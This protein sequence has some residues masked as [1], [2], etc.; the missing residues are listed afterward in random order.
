MDFST[1]GWTSNERR[2]S[3]YCMPGT[4]NRASAHG[5]RSTGA[6]LT[7]P[8]ENESPP[9]PRRP[10]ESSPP[11]PAGPLPRPTI[12]RPASRPGRRCRAQVLWPATRRAFLVAFA[13]LLALPLQA[14]AQTVV[15]LV[16]SLTS[17]GGPKLY[18]ARQSLG[19][20]SGIHHRF[21]HRWLH[22]YKH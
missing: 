21:K 20:C 18:C 12:A 13:A 15:T 11:S 19:D 14:Q 6:R 8:S 9:G 17:D 2:D 7:H 4:E 10:P 1:P 16:N 5:H 22:A 3:A